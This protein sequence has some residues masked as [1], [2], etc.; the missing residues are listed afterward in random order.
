[1]THFTELQ[2]SLNAINNGGLILYPTDTVWCIGCDPMDE[3]AVSNLLALRQLP[4]GHPLILLVSDMEMLKS[5]VDFIHPRVETLLVHHQ[6]PLTMIFD[7]GIGLPSGV[8][9]ADGSVTLRVTSDP[10]CLELIQEL[11]HPLVA[12]EACIGSDP[13]PSHFGEVSSAVIEKVKYVVRH[14]QMDKQMEEPSVIARLN[15]DD[16]LDFLRE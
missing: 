6:R 9:G 5:Y 7:K 1:M 13:I 11:G 10:L 8:L 16:E 12:T 14:R 4:A 3:D 2:P 15:K